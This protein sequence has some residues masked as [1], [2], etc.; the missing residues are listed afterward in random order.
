[1]ITGDK[2]YKIVG[3]WDQTG[4]KLN[5]TKIYI[6]MHDLETGEFVASMD[7]DD[8]IINDFDDS[9]EMR[10]EFKK[11]IAE[12]LESDCT[13]YLRLRG[14][15]INSLVADIDDDDL[16]AVNVFKKNPEKGLTSG[17]TY[18]SVSTPFD[19]KMIVRLSF[20]KTFLESRYDALAKEGF[21]S[22]GCCADGADSR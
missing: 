19:C 16:K 14:D 15:V 7:I 6:G 9:A 17:A 10:D 12:T 4:G 3:V 21:T 5:F 2:S 22:Q 18:G 11:N 20:L 8:N 1:M 13:E